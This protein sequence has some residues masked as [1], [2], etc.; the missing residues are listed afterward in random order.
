MYDCRA[1]KVYQTS[2][3][4]GYGA[5]ALGQ[6]RRDTSFLDFSLRQSDSSIGMERVI[7]LTAFS[8]SSLGLGCSGY[9]VGCDFEYLFEP[10]VMT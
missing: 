1:G 9:I 6:L 4:H 3:K 10:D 8:N 7:R 5:Y 2:D